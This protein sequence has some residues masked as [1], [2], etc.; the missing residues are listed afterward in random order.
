MY[1]LW[2]VE[3]R[4]TKHHFMVAKACHGDMVRGRWKIWSRSSLVWKDLLVGTEL[5]LKNTM[6]TL[7]A[8]SATCESQTRD[9]ERR[10]PMSGRTPERSLNL[11]GSVNLVLEMITDSVRV[12]RFTNNLEQELLD[13]LV[14]ANMYAPGTYSCLLEDIYVRSL[15]LPPGSSFDTELAR[16]SG[17]VMRRRSSYLWKLNS[18]RN[19]LWKSKRINLSLWN[20]TD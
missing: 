7:V 9:A 6:S 11:M 15:L 17:P 4:V 18:C 10:L 13:D 8:G 14:S 12:K 1:C 19:I 2:C 16:C 5:I 3:L 20:F